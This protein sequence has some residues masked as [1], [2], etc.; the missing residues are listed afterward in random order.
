MFYDSR[1][2]LEQPKLR[3]QDQYFGIWK[4]CDELQT[5]RKLFLNLGL[6]ISMEQHVSCRKKKTNNYYEE[7]YFIE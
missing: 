5:N 4:G 2:I 6:N 1:N 3:F 7:I